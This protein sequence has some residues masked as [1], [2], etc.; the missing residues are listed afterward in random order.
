MEPTGPVVWLLS[1]PP[2]GPTLLLPARAL[3]GLPSM[4]CSWR[5][6]AH[7]QLLRVALLAALLFVCSTVCVIP[8]LNPS[9]SQRPPIHS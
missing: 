5:A 3:Q 2:F 7:N 1:P 4:P 6:P 8:H 9:H